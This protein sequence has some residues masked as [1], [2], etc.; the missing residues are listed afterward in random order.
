M[1][2][3]KVKGKGI[4][5]GSVSSVYR[6]YRP[7]GIPLLFPSSL[8][9]DLVSTKSKS[10]GFHPVRLDTNSDHEKFTPLLT[11]RLKI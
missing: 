10:Y 7:S 5:S 4:L 2:L 8:K 9:G 11:E 1:S 6:R 3:K